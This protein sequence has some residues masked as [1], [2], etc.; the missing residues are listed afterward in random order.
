M[1]CETFAVGCHRLR[2]GLFERFS[3]ASHFPPVAP[4]SPGGAQKRLH[5][6]ARLRARTPASSPDRASPM[7]PAP[8]LQIR[9]VALGTPK[10][11]RTPFDGGRSPA[12]DE[13]VGRG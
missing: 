11:V 1:R 9:A 10:E 13:L 4:V 6:C 12:P 5:L 8:V 3:R 7:S 2:I